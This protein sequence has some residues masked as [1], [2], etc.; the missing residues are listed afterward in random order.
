[1][2]KQ[3]CF[4]WNEQ[5]QC[6]NA[7][8]KLLCKKGECSFYKTKEQYELDFPQSDK[9][10]PVYIPMRLRPVIRLDD[11]KY[12]A[13]AEAAAADSGIKNT[14][15]LTDHIQHR[16]YQSCGGYHWRWATKKEVKNHADS[17]SN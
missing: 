13:T 4:A 11:D 1:M 10:N 5:R 15:M 8:L 16:R 17:Y 12:Y 3:D 6:C 7:L 9:V 2:T 14:V